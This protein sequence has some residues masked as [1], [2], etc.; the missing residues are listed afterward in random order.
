MTELYGL[1]YNKGWRKPELFFS[2]NDHWFDWFFNFGFATIRWTSFISF[3]LKV[4]SEKERERGGGGGEGETEEG[5]NG[6]TE[7]QI[8]EAG[9]TETGE[10]AERQ[11][12]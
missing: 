3:F 7:R 2:H 12:D 4:P 8:E 6:E 9:Q 1:Y 11:G 10:L 5:A